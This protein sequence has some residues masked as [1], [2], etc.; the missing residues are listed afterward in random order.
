MWD[1]PAACI[2]V[3]VQWGGEEYPARII[4]AMAGAVNAHREEDWAMRE[5]EQKQDLVM[6]MCEMFH[7]ASLYH[8]DVIDNADIRR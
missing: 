5:V 7:T 8:D 4:S 2:Q 6:Q 3:S 1:R